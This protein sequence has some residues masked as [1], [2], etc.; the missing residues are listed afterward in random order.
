MKMYAWETFFGKKIINKRKN[1]I[2][3]LRMLLILKFFSH[4][5]GSICRKL[6]FLLVLLCYIWFGHSLTSEVVYYITT[7]FYRLSRTISHLIPICLG[8]GAELI[9]CMNRIESILTAEEIEETIQ[10]DSNLIIIPKV[11]FV[12]V[13]VGFSSF[14]ILKDVNMKLKPGLNVLIGPVG[15]GKS[16]LLKAILREYVILNGKVNI[17]GSISYCPQN[18]WLFPSSIKQNIIFGQTFIESKYKT[19]LNSCA[20]SFDLDGLAEGD[21]TVLNDCGVNLSKGQQARVNIARALY[22][23]SNIYILDDCLSALDSHVKN[24]IFANS[25]QNYLK[26]KMVILATHDKKFVDKADNV[27]IMM[28]GTVTYSGKPT[29]IPLKVAVSLESLDKDLYD[30]EEENDQESK[31]GEEEKPCNE[32]T[33]LIAKICT[34]NK[35]NIYHETL[36]TGGIKWKDYKKYFSFGGGFYMF[37]LVFAIAITV[38]VCY[39]YS[40]KLLSKWVLMEEKMSLH[41]SPS[42]SNLTKSLTNVLNQTVTP[43]LFENETYTERT[44]AITENYT[45]VSSNMQINNLNTTIDF[46]EQRTFFI[47]LYSNL[48]FLS[49]LLFFI[50][51]VLYFIFSLKISKNLHNAMITKVLG[52]KMSFF[53][54]NMS[55][56]ILNRFSKDLYDIDEWIPFI[57]NEAIKMATLLTTTGILISSISPFFSIMTV[58]LVVI[59]FFACRYCIKPGRNLRRL[60]TATRSPVVGHLNATLEGLITI[61][62]YG[63]Q[64]ILVNEFDKHQDLLIASH[65]LFEILI[66]C[67]AFTLHM[68]AAGYVS[69]IVLKFLIADVESSS[70]VGLA[71]TQSFVLSNYLDWGLRQWVMLESI[72]TSFQRAA[73]YTNIKQETQTGQTVEN[74][75]SEGCIKYQNVTLKYRANNETVLKNLNFVIRPKEKIGIVGRTGAGKSSII[76]TLFRLYE[77]EG[78]ILIDDVNIKTLPLDFLRNHIGI[79]PQD[80]ILFSGTVRVNIDPLGRHSD[81]EIWQALNAVNLK[82]AIMDL[83]EDVHECGLTHSVGQRQLIC[84]AR[85]IIRKTKIIILDEAT[86]NMDEETD[87]FVHDKIHELFEHC[88]TITVAHRLNS[89]MRC[90][91]V[92]VMDNGEIIEFENPNTLLENKDSTFTKWFT[93]MTIHDFNF[94]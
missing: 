74:W 93:I 32:D 61:R 7:C 76:V 38:E 4:F 22:K 13:D 55:G 87:K 34:S 28:D 31:E 51:T 77:V 20:L 24:Y 58:I 79:I 56:N 12:S 92:I 65:H 36:I 25:I 35:A 48:L 39:G 82:S 10:D 29:D 90:D 11:D 33:E 47:Y 8:T 14:P 62:A 44:E 59:F 67:L 63:T 19:I 43:Y 73:E 17:E 78:D 18:P 5:L 45:A 70:S 2:R 72:M 57:I 49:T 6:S 37:F 1:E 46:L 60:C 94:Q 91:R 3:E 9:A 64:S 40:E 16:S 50:G 84:L 53:D 52:A 86:A 30:S 71:I 80:P 54:V 85:A 89:V 15:C 27:I 41:L 83:D 21:E 26:D 66:R 81:D 69:L 68:L 23:E 75:P 88:T 42:N